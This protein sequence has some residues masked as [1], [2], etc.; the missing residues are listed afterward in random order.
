MNNGDNDNRIRRYTFDDTAI[1][2]NDKKPNAR[3]WPIII[4]IIVI[5]A[6]ILGGVKTVTY[7]TTKHDA[8][9]TKTVT[10]NSNNS[11]GDV[12]TSQREE[13]MRSKNNNAN[14]NNNNNSKKD[15]FAQRHIFS[16]VAD[17]QN[18]AKATQEQW[19]KA[20]YQTYTVSADSQGYY[21][22][23]FVK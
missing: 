20:G 10:K 18:Y 16:S 4:L 15:M 6:L 1:K 12:T 8:P 14:K 22:L 21:I 23:R 9:T 17:A 11:S 5:S 13:M 3:I 2:T 7:F 19:L